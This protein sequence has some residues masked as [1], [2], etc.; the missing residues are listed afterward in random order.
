MQNIVSEYSEFFPE[1][2]KKGLF[3]E[4]SLDSHIYLRETRLPPKE[5]SL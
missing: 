2:I 1:E 5:G 4:I 3:V